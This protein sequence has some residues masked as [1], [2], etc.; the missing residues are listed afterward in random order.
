MH[1]CHN[2]SFK[3]LNSTKKFRVATFVPLNYSLLCLIIF[4]MVYPVDM[5]HTCSINLDFHQ[6]Q[7]IWGKVLKL[8][9]MTNKRKINKNNLIKPISSK[10]LGTPSSGRLRSSRA[11]SEILAWSN[12]HQI[13]YEKII[14]LRSKKESHNNRTWISIIREEVVYLRASESL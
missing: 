8:N 3:V 11:L 5:G 9:K 2:T 10:S 6:L 14:T 7:I 1:S 4:I 12:N 13:N